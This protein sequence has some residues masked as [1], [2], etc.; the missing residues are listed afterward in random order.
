[1]NTK[2]FYMGLCLALLMC[3]FLVAPV[4]AAVG[5]D[6]LQGP[7]GTVVTVSNLPPGQSYLV[8]WDGIVCAAGMMPS[9]TVTFTVPETALGSHAVM[10]QSPQGTQVFTGMFTVVP[11]ITI[12]PESGAVGTTISTSGKGFATSESIT[13]TYDG[14]SMST[15]IAANS[16]G[17]W[18]TTFAV[19]ASPGGTH[20][21][22]ALGGVTSA[23]N[24]TTK[25]FTVKPTIE[26]APLSGSV[27]TA[28]T[29]RGSGFA[30]SE[31]GIKVIFDSKDMK[32]GI[33]AGSNGSWATTF[34][35]PRTSGGD[36]VIDAWGSTTQAA[37]IG[38]INFSVVSGISIDKN[39][40]YVGDIIN[41]RGTGFGQNETGISVTIDGV[42]MGSSI[43]ADQN[44]E[45]SVSMSMPVCAN[46]A[47]TI[48]A[49]G[50]MTAASSALNKTITILAKIVLNPATGNVDDTI[51]VA[52]S[53]FGS[54]KNIT[55]TYGGDP[56]PT[57][58]SA[59][60]TG[61]FTGSFK[62]PKG[63][64]GDIKVVA[65]GADG[66]TASSIFAMETVVPPVPQIT[67][68]TSG[69]TV[70]LIGDAKVNFE[71]KAVTDPSGAYYDLQLASDQDFKS[72]VFEH[73]GLAAPEYKSTDAEVLHHGEYYWRLRSV[74]GA[75]NTSEWTV[76]SRLKAGYISTSMLIM[77]L[78]AAI[79]I[80]AIVLRARSVFFKR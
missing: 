60:A 45:W 56:V 67:Y 16:N 66:V 50:N 2:T 64:H 8:Q 62:A 47:H 12:S 48:N 72:V 27:D 78:I 34:N 52:G 63:K 58:A 32:T 69:K 33:A 44:G 80:I 55:I 51:N 77:I 49:R 17:S 28:V 23:I 36:H 18:S 13:V 26:V 53:G 39:T 57:G 30:A 43:V 46:G 65:T 68:P 42:A 75:G 15:G 76:S 10:V 54:N 6:L 40:A 14:T 20:Q 70:G 7:V 79:V 74:D 73:S 31:S 11:G 22:G 1:V 71:W 61:S 59:D 24:V 9:G 3:F 29:V 41:F 19:P 37:D 35:V 4:F 5:I 21:V 38:D 25:T